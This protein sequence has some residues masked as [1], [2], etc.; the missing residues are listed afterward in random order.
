MA[1]YSIERFNRII[2]VRGLALDQLVADGLYSRPMEFKAGREGSR[3]M[4]DV[5]SDAPMSTEFAISR[6][7]VP[8]VAKYG[9]ALFLDCDVLC[10]ENVSN[11]FA[12]ADDSKAVMCVKHQHV[13]QEGTKMDGQIQ[14][15]YDRKNWSSVMLFNCEHPS[16]SRLTL[17]LINGVP[18]RDL[19]RFCWLEDDEIGELPKKWNYLVGHDNRKSVPDPAIVHF[20]NGLPDVDGRE[21]QEFSVNWHKYLPHAVGVW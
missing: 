1:R 16:N 2:P 9:W 10:F 21:M 19:H 12:L 20:T 17:D 8:H 6:F 4:W 14:T 13:P 3:Q 5:I 15:A 11:L 18:G 7:L